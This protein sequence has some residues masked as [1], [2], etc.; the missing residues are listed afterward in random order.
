MTE[1][2]IKDKIWHRRIFLHKSPSDKWFRNDIHSF[3]SQAGVKESADI[4]YRM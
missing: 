1:D 3:L 2:Q 4:I